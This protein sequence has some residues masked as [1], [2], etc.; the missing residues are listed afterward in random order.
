MGMSKLILAVAFLAGCVGALPPS[1][2]AGP[3]P[4]VFELAMQIVWDD[5][6]GMSAP[7]PVITWWAPCSTPT[8]ADPFR[9]EGN[10]WSDT[11]RPDN[12]MDLRWMGRFSSTPF[13]YALLEARGWTLYGESQVETSGPDKNLIPVAQQALVAAGL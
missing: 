7:R 11:V 9:P 10:C 5:V 6:Y 4:D 8:D 13:S 3:A 2:I 1:P 12:T